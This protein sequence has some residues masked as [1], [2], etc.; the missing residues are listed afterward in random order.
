[1]PYSRSNMNGVL[2]LQEIVFPD[3]LSG[4]LSD[5]PVNILDSNILLPKEIQDFFRVLWWNGGLAF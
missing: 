4:L 5:V 2:G 3:Q 1:M